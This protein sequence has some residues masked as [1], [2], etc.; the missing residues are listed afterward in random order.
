MRNVIFPSNVYLTDAELVA[1]GQFAALS[2]TLDV[3][4]IAGDPDLS[5]G[6]RQ[7]PGHQKDSDD[8]TKDSCLLE[9][10]RGR[11]RCF[12]ASRP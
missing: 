6:H 4:V 3:S 8:S 12:S 10:V 9:R 5:S 11:N 7:R 1:V 2:M